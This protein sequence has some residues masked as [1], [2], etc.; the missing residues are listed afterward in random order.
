MDTNKDSV[1]LEKVPLK[2]YFSLLSQYLRPQL[3]RVIM[4][5]IFMLVGIGLNLLTPQIM[6]YF[7][8]TA[9]AGGAT[10]NLVI[11]GVLFVVVGLVQQGVFLVSSYL[12]QDVGWRATNWMRENLALHCLKLDMGFHHEHTPGEMVERVDGDTTTLANFFSEF[13]GQVIGSTLFLIGVLAMIFREDWRVGT[14]MTVFSLIAFWV[15]NLTRNFAVPA[16]TA[17]R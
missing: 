12:G 14:V 15:F 4:L 3:G 13:V 6:R 10:Q 1:P 7:I 8:D 2:Q 17:E 9:Q 16:F 11:A 5:G